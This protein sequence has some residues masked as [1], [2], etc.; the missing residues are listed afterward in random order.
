MPTSR[1]VQ[2]LALTTTVFD[3]DGAK[4][5]RVILVRKSTDSREREPYLA[6]T[7]TLRHLHLSLLLIQSTSLPIT[8]RPF[9]KFQWPGTFDD[10]QRS[11]DGRNHGSGV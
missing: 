10:Y 9:S 4:R 11:G 8:S 7:A 5:R 1:P 3:L 2:P 6:A